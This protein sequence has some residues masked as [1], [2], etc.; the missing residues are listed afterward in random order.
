MAD[1][2]TPAG[3]VRKLFCNQYLRPGGRVEVEQDCTLPAGNKPP[4]EMYALL[5]QAVEQNLLRKFQKWAFS[6]YPVLAFEDPALVNRA[7]T[8][9]HESESWIIVSIEKMEDGSQYVFMNYYYSGS[10]RTWVMDP[11]LLN[12]LQEAL[13]TARKN[14]L[15]KE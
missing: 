3:P 10:S 13:N 6:D 4:Q 11:E 14:L 8:K 15:G 12:P 9:G 2:G 7:K 1:G 5:K